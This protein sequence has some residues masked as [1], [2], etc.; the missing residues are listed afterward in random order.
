MEEYLEAYIRISAEGAPPPHVTAIRVFAQGLLTAL[1]D[2]T[3]LD[4]ARKLLGDPP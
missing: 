3:R 4:R 1:R 2:D